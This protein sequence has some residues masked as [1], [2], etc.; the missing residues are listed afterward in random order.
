MKFST[1]V[2]SS[3]A[4]LASSV[5]AFD[6]PNI[7]GA[8]CEVNSKD[9]FEVYDWEFQSFG[10]K[11][12]YIGYWYTANNPAVHITL[13]G[14]T[15]GT[16]FFIGNNAVKDCSCIPDTQPDYRLAEGAKTE[17]DVTV[18]EGEL[19]GFRMRSWGVDFGIDFQQETSMWSPLM[20][21]EACSK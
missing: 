6:I 19:L 10:A 15:N 20:K 1:I 21:L 4:S 14:G 8:T 9:W 5:N 18:K 16:D 2:L 7:A 11:D 13:T 3:V 12:Q 17:L